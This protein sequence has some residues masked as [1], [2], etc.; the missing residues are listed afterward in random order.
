MSVSRSSSTD[1][2]NIPLTLLTR[3]DRSPPSAIPPTTKL[4]DKPMNTKQEPSADLP[5]MDP[6]NSGEGVL[7]G[8]LRLETSESARGQ[9]MEEIIEKIAAVEL[10][11]Q[12][13]KVHATSERKEERRER[14]QHAGDTFGQALPESRL[15]SSAG[16]PPPKPLKSSVKTGQSRPKSSTNVVNTDPPPRSKRSSPKKATGSTGPVR[17]QTSSPV[18]VSRSRNPSQAF[19]QSTVHESKVEKVGT[20]PEAGTAPVLPMHDDL[21]A[22]SIHMD[23][24]PDALKF[25]ESVDKWTGLMRRAILA[26]FITAKSDLLRR[27]HQLVE[28]ARQGFAGEVDSLSDQ[29]RHV[30]SQIAFYEKKAEKREKLVDAALLYLTRKREKATAALLFGRWRS[31]HAESRRLRLAFK[32]TQQYASKNLQRK[33]L[34]G[35]QRAAGT[36]WR[37]TV[38][39]KIKMEA[40][41]AMENLAGEYEKRIAVIKEEL[42]DVHARLDESERERSLQQEDMKKAFMRGVCALNMEAMSMFRGAM[43]NGEMMDGMGGYGVDPPTQPSH[44]NT[45]YRSDIQPQQRTTDWDDPSRRDRQGGLAGPNSVLLP[46][47]RTAT[48]PS[49][50]DSLKATIESVTNQIASKSYSSTYQ[51]ISYQGRG[52]A[53]VTRHAQQAAAGWARG[54]GEW[55]AG[56]RGIPRLGAVP[57]PQRYPS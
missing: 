1:S 46:P 44:L 35:W 48:F 24:D 21:M 30:R 36:T 47:R 37:R 55:S 8:P 56:E 5:R 20:E 49:K 33:M 14:G 50:P 52:S 45:G 26:D 28:S 43:A 29:L 17:S 22:D 11:E 57:V 19:A 38:E 16:N 4:N 39:R 18:R 41:K 34:L 15:K 42:D 32:L 9:D 12:A 10:V 2:L 13:G 53:F 3:T 27:Q 6:D 7:D 54:A 23:I 51:P 40:E 25:G 31:K